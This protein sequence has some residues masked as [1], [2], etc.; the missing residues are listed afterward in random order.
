MPDVPIVNRATVAAPK[1]Y[2]LP[3]S[4]EI[5]LKAV[6]AELDG[7][8]AAGSFL[9]ALQLVSNNGDVMFTAVL[10]STPI[11]A[12]G[13]AS[14]SW[15]PLKKQTTG[16]P[17]PSPNPLGT[18]FAWYDFAD[19]TT[20][21]LDGSNNIQTIKDKTGNG[22]DASQAIAGQRPSQS[23]LNA[24]NCGIFVSAHPDVLVSG[25]WPTILNQPFTIALVWTQ[26]IAS[27][28]NYQPGP[29]G[30]DDTQVPQGIPILFDN[31]NNTSLAMEQGAGTILV[32]QAAPYTQQQ[33]TL[34]YN[35]ASS[36]FRLNGVS[37]AGSVDSSFSNNIALGA[38]HYP[39]HTPGIVQQMDGKLGEVLVYNSALTAAQL[40]A[41]ESYLKTKWAT[42]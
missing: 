8:N 38:S 16:A 31:F 26:S 7:T 36:T 21:T 34:T 1:D 11:V 14:V 15:F 42:P 25:G 20:I 40:T 27:S 17:A 32:S 30:G 2:T 23:T 39:N 9:P 24:L 33:A 4:Q 18:L 35:A 12:G 19:T 29:V 3:Q 6:R 37:H 13:S 5:L 22:H 28:A 10:T 41:V